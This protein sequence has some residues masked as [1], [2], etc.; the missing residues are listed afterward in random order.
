MTHSVQGTAVRAAENIAVV[1]WLRAADEREWDAFVTAHRFGL[2]YH[3]SPWKRVL[4]KAFPHITGKFLVARNG[5]NGE[6]L[7]GIPVYTVKS[8]L[9]GNRIVSVPFATMCDPL[10]STADEF[11]LFLP[12]LREL[13]QGTK[14]RRVEIR[15]RKTATF[16]SQNAALRGDVG[17]KHLYISLESD[18]ETLFRT[19]SRTS[20]RKNITKANNSG[21]VVERRLDSAGMKLCYDILCAARRRNSLPQIPFAFFQA[22]LEALSPNHISPFLAFHNGNP[23][24][25]FIMMNIGDFWTAE[26]V[27]VFDDAPRG[28][29]QLLY[30]ESIKYAH[31]RGGKIYSFGRTAV[32]NQGLLT[33]KRR[34]APMEEDLA[35]FTFCARGE[36]TESVQMVHHTDASLVY[37]ATRAVLGK[38]PLS[39]YRAIGDFCYHHLG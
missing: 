17:F 16:L 33:Y 25:C 11:D 32:A 10:V 28:V 3:L 27:G 4:E 5:I 18:R 36:K 24:G 1:E 23:V 26:Y 34:W 20:V 37:R 15:A 31:G 2:V 13:Q 38:V 21:V 35:D 22:M 6:I 19:F 39:I 9:L 14:S 12:A 30:W 29:D 7:A 8:W